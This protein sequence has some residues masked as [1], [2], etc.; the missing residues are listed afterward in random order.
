MREPSLCE[1]L[2]ECDET[3]I[4]RL[5]EFVPEDMDLPRAPRDGVILMTCREGLNE[6]FHLGE[7]LVSETLVRWRGVEGYA[8]VVGDDP[9]RSLVAAAID[10]MRQ[11]QASPPDLETLLSAAADALLARRTED[12]RAA[13]S[14]RVEF[15]LLPGA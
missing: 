9:R 8:V 12:A 15:D 13:A 10:A 1:V 6:T 7:V 11:A 5:L 14:T 3:L 2:S 4:V